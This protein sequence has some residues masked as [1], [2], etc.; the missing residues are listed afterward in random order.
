MVEITQDLVADKLLWPL[1]VCIKREYKEQ[2]KKGI[3]EQFE[4]AIMSS[5]NCADLRTFLSTIKR[6]LPIEIQA[7]YM[8]DIAE[9]IESG[10]DSE[11]L[12]WFRD[13]PAYLVIKCRL[14][15]DGRKELFNLKKENT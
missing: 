12:A 4:H 2:Y 14:T 7:Q 10:H 6:R 8:K 9:V 15:N 11:I 13:Q 5:S 1:W 3:W